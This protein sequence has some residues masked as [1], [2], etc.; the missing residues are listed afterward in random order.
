M[1]RYLRVANLALMETAALEFESGLVSVTG[2]TGAGK[3]VL[4]GALQLL[5]GS[6]A[7]KTMI[8]QGAESCS[9][10][11]ALYFPEP[12]AINAV[13]EASGLP[14][15]EDG[16]LLLKRTF[17][18]S[19][20]PQIQVNG[21]LSTLAQLQDLGEHWIDF[22][23]P[24]EPQKLYKEKWQLALLDRYAKAESVLTPYG[25]KYREW[26]DILKQIDDLREQEQLDPDE[27]EYLQRQI[28]A[29]DKAAL[30]E[31]GVEELERDFTRLSKAQDLTTLARQIESALAGDGGVTEMLGPTL[32]SARQLAR[33][34][35]KG[36]ELTARL[37]ALIIEAG[38][39]AGEFSDL[40]GSCEFDEAQA[41]SINTRMDAWLELKRKHG[42]NIAQILKKRDALAK[43]LATQGDIEGA[44]S[45]LEASAGKLK[46]ELLT[47]AE[48]LKKIREKSAKELSTQ[49]ERVLGKLGFK[50]GKLLIEILPENDLTE[51]GDSAC[52]FLFTPN[53]GQ[54]PLPLSKI[55]S[56]GEAARVML[57]LK[58]VLAQVDETPV[59]VFDEVDAN[60]GGEIARAV[61]LELAALGKKHQVFCVTHQP[62]VAALAEQHYVV[63]KQQ[64]DSS[65]SIQIQIVHN[66]SDRRIGELARMMGD[67]Q[68][69]TARKHAAEL[70]AGQ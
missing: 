24:G 14:L 42:P 49:T 39:L 31:E 41:E 3:S 8:R 66:D 40:A 15:C 13:L 55:A 63:E 54:P 36:A 57:A 51:H 10:E 48:Q 34:D 33:I 58:A 11:A 2:E 21:G 20:M 18:R 35:A 5:S 16:V 27:Q 50:K 26:R 43:K 30:T 29:I 61:G 64:T 1:L 59:L 69:E 56:S 9:L 23:G 28:D 44:I 7:E 37:E 68:S 52:R 45:K 46:K 65:T 62:Q 17:S 22:H 60:V 67:R 70:L 38:D 6:R 19:K 53:A 12:A 4:I 47:L 25:K 32:Q